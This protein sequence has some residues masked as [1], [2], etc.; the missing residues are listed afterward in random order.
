[1]RAVA[2]HGGALPADGGEH[3]LAL[4]A[5]RQR[6]ARD[7]VHDLGV[8]DV[9]E[10]V[11]PVLLLALRPH[12]G[13][14]ELGETVDVEGLDAELRLEVRAHRLAPGLGA[15]EPGPQLQGAH[16]HAHVPGVLRHEHR[17]GRRARQRRGPEVHHGLELAHRVAG[18][19]GDDCGADGLGAV[20]HPEPAREQAVAVGV[21]DDVVAPHPAHVQRAGHDVPPHLEV[22]AGV[23]V[24]HRLAGGA[25]RHVDLDDLG[26][27]HREQAEGVPLAHVRLGGE[28]EAGEVREGVDVGRCHAERVH[29]VPVEG[30]ARVEGG[31]EPLQALELEPLQLGARQG[32]D[33]LIPHRGLPA[34]G[35][36]IAGF[37]PGVGP[38]R[39]PVRGR[40]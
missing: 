13:A 2:Q 15:E 40:S 9:L 36:P 25:R 1:V 18:R 22:G 10:D 7:R 12:A 20:V 14:D 23:A 32:L 21:L 35:W 31:H 24:H 27:V 28:G 29:A 37:P 8:E 17:V 5:R 4:G 34:V 39:R 33:G 6:F 30:H 16:V 38:A 26:R 19:D 11:E 3:Q